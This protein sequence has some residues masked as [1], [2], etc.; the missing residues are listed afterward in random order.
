MSGLRKLGHIF[1]IYCQ[2]TLNGASLSK[3]HNSEKGEAIDH[4][5]EIMTK[6]V[7]LTCVTRS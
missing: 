6:I 2:Y 5:Q 3:P 4:A 1:A 7:L